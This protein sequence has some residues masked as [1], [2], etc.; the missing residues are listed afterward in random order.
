MR[1]VPRHQSSDADGVG[2]SLKERTKPDRALV[3][4]SADVVVASDAKLPSTEKTQSQT[5]RTAKTSSGHHNLKLRCDWRA[6]IISGLL[7]HAGAGA[8]PAETALL[9]ALQLL[10]LPSLPF[11][12]LAKV[13]KCAMNAICATH[14]SVN[15]CAGLALA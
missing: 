7:V 5:T 13:A 12:W 4:N 8:Q 6:I 10:L 2:N 15:E 3:R 11:A 1:L 9:H 14:R